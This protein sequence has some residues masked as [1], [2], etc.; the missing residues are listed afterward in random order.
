MSDDQRSQESS[1]LGILHGH[2]PLM[3]LLGT[4]TLRID[5]GGVHHKVGERIEHHSPASAWTPPRS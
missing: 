1:T 3:A 2:V 4:G 5:R